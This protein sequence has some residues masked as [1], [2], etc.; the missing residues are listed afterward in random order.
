MDSSMIMKFCPKCMRWFTSNDDDQS[1][2][3]KCY[4]DI[5]SSSDQRVDIRET[6]SNLFACMFCL[7]K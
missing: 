1:I 7:K 3:L 5:D 2:C 4:D 6:V